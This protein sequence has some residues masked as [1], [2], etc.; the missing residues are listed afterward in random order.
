MAATALRTR[1]S[2]LP[3]LAAPP[4]DGTVVADA[5][6]V[7]EVERVIDLLVEA[8]KVLVVALLDSDDSEGKD[9]EMC[10]GAETEPE[11]DGAADETDAGAE[12]TGAETGADEDATADP[13]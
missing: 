6:G 7:A 3:N 12:E 9:E 8:V 5:D 10:D 13:T 1:A 2:G 4:V 11:T